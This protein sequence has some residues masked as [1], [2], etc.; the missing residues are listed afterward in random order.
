MILPKEEMLEAYHHDLIEHARMARLLKEANLE[1]P[2]LR[3][4]ILYSAGDGL[5]SLGQRLR[6]LAN[7]EAR[8]VTGS[9]R[10]SFLVRT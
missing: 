1:K 3:S 5:V 4:Q 10:K 9:D 7:N 2:G 8:E 6:D